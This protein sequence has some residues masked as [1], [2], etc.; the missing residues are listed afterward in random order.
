MSTLNVWEEVSVREDYKLIGTTWGFRTK[1]D[2]HHRIIE[3][4]ACLCAQG[5]SQMQGKYYSKT[6]APTGQLPLRTLI[7]HAAASN[8]KF[9]QLDIKSAFLNAP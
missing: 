8:L 7:L 5:F 1:T 9:E 6:F 2:E 4:K 3:H